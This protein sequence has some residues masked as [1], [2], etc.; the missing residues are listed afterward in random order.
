M[1]DYEPT[2]AD[3]YSK[4]IAFDGETEESQIDIL[5]TAGQEDYA[6]AR[7]NYIR[8]GEGFMCVYSIADRESFDEIKD[9]RDQIL[10]VHEDGGSGA[11]PI[12]L[13]GNKCDLEDQRQ[14]A[15][16]EAASLARSWGCP[17]LET[18]AKTDVN[19]NQAFF[20]LAKMVRA[21]KQANGAGE[22]ESGGCPCV[23][24]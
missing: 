13:V 11:K 23:I 8:N 24:A 6:A 19:V 12:L 21:D 14:V 22:E 15:K 9:F 10:R 17:H 7:D 16:E 18:S 1:P 4:K 20:D 2:K 3:A 5:D